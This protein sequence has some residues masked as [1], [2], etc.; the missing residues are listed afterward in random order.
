MA[1]F[2]EKEK[3]PVQQTVENFSDISPAVENKS[4]PVS[5]VQTQF[6]ANVTDSAGKPLIE[7]VE[8]RKIEICLPGTTEELTNLSKGSPE[9]GPTWFGAYWV[10]MLKKA[11]YW[12]WNIITGGKQDVAV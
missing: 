11:F 5:P 9:D 1:L 12:G 8:N 2:P 4:L 10:R 3:S 6:T 7:T